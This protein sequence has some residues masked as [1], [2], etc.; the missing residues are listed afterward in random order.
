MPLLSEKCLFLHIP[1]TGGTSLSHSL[2]KSDVKC[3]SNVYTTEGTRYVLDHCTV[4]DLVNLKLLNKEDICNMYVFCCV[5]NTF[6][7]LVSIYFH[8][9]SINCPSFPKFIEELSVYKENTRRRLPT[10]T[11]C[12]DNLFVSQKE[13]LFFENKIIVNDI[14]HFENYYQMLE[15][16][17]TKFKRKVAINK[18]M[19]CSVNRKNDYRYYCTPD[20]RKR[21]ESIYAE[22]ID[23]FKFGY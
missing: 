17:S 9:G 18:Y 11:S 5:R 22:E 8:S 2:I 1:R 14:F 3:L 20:A 12:V 19:N 4:E 7:R 15:K 23:Y 10:L 13:Y 21:V 16:L 6:D